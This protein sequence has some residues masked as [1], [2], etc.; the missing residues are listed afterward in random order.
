MKGGKNGDQAYPKAFSH[1]IT[2]L[3]CGFCTKAFAVAIPFHSFSL[4]HCLLRL[5]FTAITKETLSEIKWKHLEE[6][7][8]KIDLPCINLPS[9]LLKGHGRGKYKGVRQTTF[10]TPEANVI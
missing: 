1:Q 9:E 7:W 5:N 4:C 8:E 10:L 6:N 3:D 2:L